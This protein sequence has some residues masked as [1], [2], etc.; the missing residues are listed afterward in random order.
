M[1]LSFAE[2]RALQ[3]IVKTNLAALAAGGI[4][5][6]DKRRLQRELTD[7]MAKLNA[8]VDIPAEVMPAGWTKRV[9]TGDDVYSHANGITQVYVRQPG[10]T[11]AGAYRIRVNGEGVY[12]GYVGERT[13]DIPL[14]AVLAMALKYTPSKG[15]EV[16]PAN[17]NLADLIAGKFDSL[18]PLA[19]LGKLKEI[20]DEI[21]DIE[22][23]KGPA[24]AYIEK[25]SDKVTS[26]MESAMQEA[27]GKLWNG[28]TIL[29]AAKAPATIGS[30]AWHW[31][32]QGNR[33]A[34]RGEHPQTGY[35]YQVELFRKQYE[36]GKVDEFGDT[37]FKSQKYDDPEKAAKYAEQLGDF[38][39][40][41]II[42][43]K[44][45]MLRKR[46]MENPKLAKL[47]EG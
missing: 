15:E 37:H 21:K 47:L 6:T 25:N 29:E 9:G 12:N 2:K 30:P 34:W 26:I 5:F 11:D 24:I 1:A 40:K 7:A 33:N 18:D 4:S 23:L 16:A 10:E 31:K 41:T 36:A 46:F 44:N 43:T 19:F 22:S 45:P 32:K 13:G 27:F 28:S 17:Q 35:Q 14:D 38:D 20:A 39:M 42:E 3:K 8:K